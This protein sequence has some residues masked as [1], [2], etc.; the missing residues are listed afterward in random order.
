MARVASARGQAQ[1][2]EDAL[3]EAMRLSRKVGNAD[4]PWDETLLALKE[5]LPEAR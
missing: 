2:A 4:M 3:L 1:R 5:G